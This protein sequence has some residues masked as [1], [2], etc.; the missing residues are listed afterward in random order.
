MSDDALIPFK[1][2]TDAPVFEEAWQAEALAMANT[3]VETGAISAIDWAKA[4]GAAR[5]KQVGKEETVSLYYE[6]VVTALEAELSKLGVSM[7]D[8]A[9]RKDDWIAA[10]RRTPHGQPVELL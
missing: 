6:A 8:L 7:A 1:H 4:L 10:Y 3:L 9:T 5:Q 2:E